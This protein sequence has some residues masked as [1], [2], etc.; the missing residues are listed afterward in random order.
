MILPQCKVLSKASCKIYE[1]QKLGN[2]LIWCI[3]LYQTNKKCS[4][5][6]PLVCFLL[7][8]GLQCSHNLPHDNCH[9]QLHKLIYFYNMSRW[10]C[11]K[12]IWWWFYICNKPLRVAHPDNKII[13]QRPTPVSWIKTYQI[14]VFPLCN[15][16]VDSKCMIVSCPFCWWKIFRLNFCLCCNHGHVFWMPHPVPMTHSFFRHSRNWIELFINVRMKQVEYLINS[17]ISV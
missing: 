2:V 6:H 9:K 14:Q 13:L 10:V 11:S 17:L 5:L 1:T 12:D 3:S 8:Q 4:Y 16:Q 7:P 15:L